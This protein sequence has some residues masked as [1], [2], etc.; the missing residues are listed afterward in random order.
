MK[1]PPETLKS[2]DDAIL[3]DKSRDD[4]QLRRDINKAVMKAYGALSPQTSYLL[5]LYSK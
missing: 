4:A 2:S 5:K 1:T 3:S